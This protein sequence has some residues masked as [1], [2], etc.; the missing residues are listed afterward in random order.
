[1]TEAASCEGCN[2]DAA[3]EQDSHE[4]ALKMSSSVRRP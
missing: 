2:Q 1:V 4:I 3:V